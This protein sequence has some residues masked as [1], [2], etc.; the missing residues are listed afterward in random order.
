MDSYQKFIS[1]KAK[2]KRQL[3]G[4][5]FFPRTPVLL[6]DFSE[7]KKASEYADL[8]EGLDSINLNTLVVTPDGKP[9]TETTKNIRY[10]DAKQKPTA[11]QAADFAVTLKGDLAGMWQAGCVPIARLDGNETVE[12]RPLKEEGNGFYF[13]N[14]TKWEVFAAIVRALETY[15][16]PYDW[17]NLIR[18]ILKRKA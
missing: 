5:M 3:M 2:K 13:K 16:F 14:P 8:V 12:Y 18:E 6:L 7:V 11:E 10:V 17:E 4:A 1:E 9:L 15:Q